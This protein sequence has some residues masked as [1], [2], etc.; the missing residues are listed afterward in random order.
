MSNYRSFTV[1]QYDKVSVL[2]WAESAATRD[3]HNGELRVELQA[4][5][6]TAKP[7]CVVVSFARLTRCPSALIGGLIGLKRQLA[8][9]GSG[10]QLCEMNQQL[11]EQFERLHL[12]RVFEIHDSVAEAIAA[13]EEAVTSGGQHG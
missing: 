12:D 11:R 6:L 13:C 4:F 7:P 1:E 3:S 10:L 2:T 5:V 8:E 9:R